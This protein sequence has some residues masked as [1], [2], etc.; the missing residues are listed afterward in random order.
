MTTVFCFTKA[1][2][3]AKLVKEQALIEMIPAQIGNFLREELLWH[4]QTGSSSTFSK[5]FFDAETEAIFRFSS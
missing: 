5:D 3:C 1:L 4:P 2:L